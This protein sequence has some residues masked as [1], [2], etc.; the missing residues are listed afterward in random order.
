MTVFQLKNMSL[1]N[2]RKKPKLDSHILVQDFVYY[3][4]AFEALQMSLSRF[5]EG[6]KTKKSKIAEQKMA[7]EHGFPLI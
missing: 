1:E 3:S 7:K 2:F 5:V 6:L 4:I